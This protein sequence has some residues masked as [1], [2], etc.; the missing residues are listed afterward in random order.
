M[1]SGRR[2]G[3]TRPG[4]PGTSADTFK[5]E[6]EDVD[7]DAS[8][9]ESDESETSVSVRV[10]APVG[11]SLEG[12]AGARVADLFEQHGHMVFAICRLILRDHEEAE[13]AA[14][15]AFLSAHRSLL[16]GVEPQDPA[17]WIA[18]IARNECRRRRRAPHAVVVPLDGGE[19]TLDGD[20]QQALGRSE[21]IELLCQ[22]LAE[23]PASQRQAVVLREFYGLSYAEI[24]HVLGA[25]GPAVES[26]IF[27]ARRR[28]QERLRPLRRASGILLLPVGVRDALAATIPGFS[29]G[30]GAAA[31]GG[32]AAKAVALPL[33]TKAAAFVLAVS[34]GGGIAASTPTPYVTGAGLRPETPV[35]ASPP[36]KPVAAGTGLASARGPSPAGGSDAGETA[37]T[38][39]KRDIVGGQV[40]RSE[41][42]EPREQPEP[43]EAAEA[44]EASEPAESAKPAEPADPAERPENEAAEEAESGSEVPGDDG[45]GGRADEPTNSS[46]DTQ[47]ESEH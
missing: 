5:A 26:L 42:P 7:N 31:T 44:P 27:K 8:D 13:D 18:M 33:A 22:A 3:R 2:A 11:S 46:A 17:A 29:S 30:T 24:A 41:Q 34:V 12:Q 35:A 6:D 9:D 15:Q 37:D 32:V 19:G 23:L 4:G 20:P 21:E 47:Q 39:K 10:N 43:A 40:E 1:C 28:L 45:Q 25:S 38:E 14:Q 36:A 16:R